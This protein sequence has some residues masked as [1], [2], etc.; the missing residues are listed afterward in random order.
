[1]A[2]NPTDRFAE[3]LE[4]FVELY[5]YRDAQGADTKSRQSSRRGMTSAARETKYSCTVRF[6]TQNDLQKI[7]YLKFILRFFGNWKFWYRSPSGVINQSRG[8]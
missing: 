5:G 3:Y 4:S 8:Q 6:P 2:H 7:V 1:M